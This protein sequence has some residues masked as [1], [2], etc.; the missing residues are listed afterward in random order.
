MCTNLNVYMFQCIADKYEIIMQGFIGK[1]FRKIPV[2]SNVL[3]THLNRCLT[4]YDLTMMGLATMMGGSVFTL[5][6]QVAVTSAGSGAFITF[7]LASLLGALNVMNFAEFG[8]K[9][10]TA[11]AFY[12]YSYIV[13]GEV[14]AFLVGWWA[15]FSIALTT[16]YIARSWSGALDVFFNNAIHNKTMEAFGPIVS[17]RFSPD[18]VA[19]LIVLVIGVVIV[20]GPRVSSTINNILTMFTL[21]CV[22]LMI[23]TAFTK[24]D[25][26]NWTN[27]EF[28]PHGVSGLIDG[29]AKSYIGYIGFTVVFIASEE[30]V[31]PRRSLLLSVVLICVIATLIYVLSSISLTL[32]VP[33]KSLDILA[34][35]PNALIA[36]NLSP[37]AYLVSIGTLVS[38]STAILGALYRVSRYLYVMASDRLFCTNFARLNVHK[39]PTV[40]I[41]TTTSLVVLLTALLDI[42]ALLQLVIIDSLIAFLIAATAV[43]KIR[44]TQPYR[45]PFSTKSNTED[46]ELSKITNLEKLLDTI[47]LVSADQQTIERIG[48]L[49]ARFE[50][51]ASLASLVE[52][53]E[54]FADIC[55]LGFCIMTF[56]CCFYVRV[57]YEHILS[58]ELTF[59]VMLCV[60][61]TMCFLPILFLATLQENNYLS[62]FQVGVSDDI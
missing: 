22:I 40:A 59:I 20:M 14:I 9:L 23:G 62:N 6:G 10:P 17:A 60:F 5:S 11:G 52:F 18:L 25:I 24:A 48:R 15:L 61:V 42:E 21:F 51:F 30:A 39:S 26:S 53:S 46:K 54:S 35:F 32:M 12:T 1:L 16:A 4:V 2:P 8:T 55:I 47:V 7:L 3:A 37:I 43:L 33:Y 44:Y 49:K 50:K 36:K 38:S 19:V 57:F 29:V 34:P 56:A 58:G 31:D 28:L 27:H 13:F 41:V 45:C